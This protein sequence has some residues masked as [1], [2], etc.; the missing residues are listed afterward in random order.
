MFDLSYTRRDVLRSAVGLTGLTLPT[1]LR[2]RAQAATSPAPAGDSPRAFGKAK[3]CIVIYCWGGISHYESFD[4]KPDAP[5]DVRG[6]FGSIPTSTDPSVRFCEYIPELAKHFDK[7]SVVRSVSHNDGAHS[8]AL[9]LNIT[10]HPGIKG[11]AGSR[12]NWPS[13]AATISHFVD[14]SAGTPAA[15][16]LPHSMYD[17]GRLMPGEYGGWLGSQY[18]PVLIP[19]PAGEPFGGTSRASGAELSLK[20]NLAE[21]RVAARRS[22][23]EQLDKGAGLKTTYD[24]LDRYQRM[25]ADMLLKSAL[26]EAYDL[27]SEDPRIRTM[28]GNHMGGQGMLLARRLI[29]AGV[30]VVQI[31]AGAGDLAG[32]AGDN[33][34]TLR[35]HFPKMK[36][37]LLPVFDRSVSALLTDLEQRGMLDETLVVLLTDFG[38]TP[39]VNGNGGRDHY[40]AVYSVFF[41]GGGIR[42]GQ[43]YGSSNVTGTK[44]ASDACTPA[45][46]HAT[47]YKALGI[48]H[49]AEL[50]DQLD[51]P[52]Q[53]CEGEPLPL[54]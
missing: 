51:R 45:D 21:D 15:I 18:D 23:L 4:P 40:P 25:A 53:I 14:I 11:P 32:G 37:R 46:L 16:R 24:R 19:T 54:F 48:D 17:N 43:V 29:E 47:V 41:A 49:R 36:R 5:K 33:W 9:Y 44:P 30:P 39:K 26:S 28:Y 6:E 50:H 38:R 42:G 31:C 8:S 7:M 27:D 13:L 2:A 10:G 22:L 12:E 20:L 35:V 1:F 3:S 34:D 52:F